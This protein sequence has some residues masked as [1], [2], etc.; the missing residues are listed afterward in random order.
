MSLLPLFSACQDPA[1]WFFCGGHRD[2]TLGLPFF[3][4]LVVLL[5][6]LGLDPRYISQQHAHSGFAFPSLF[7]FRSRKKR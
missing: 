3:G 7:I 4:F 6:Y 5:C 1:P 2:G